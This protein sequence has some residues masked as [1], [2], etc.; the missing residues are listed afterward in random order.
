MH[1]RRGKGSAHRYRQSYII[2]GLWNL[3][4]MVGLIL[5]TVGDLKDRNKSDMIRFVFSG[6]ILATVWKMPGNRL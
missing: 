3:L 5:K 1:L 4:R 6:Y 2:Q